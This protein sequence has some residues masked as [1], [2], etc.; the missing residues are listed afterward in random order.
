MPRAPLSFGVLV[1]LA[2]D[3][4]VL[5]AR[6]PGDEPSPVAAGGTCLEWARFAGLTADAPHESIRGTFD[7][8][9]DLGRN[10]PETLAH[11]TL[12]QLCDRGL[13]DRIPG[14]PHR[15][16]PRVGGVDRQLKRRRRRRT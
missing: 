7:R 2:A 13:V 4:F 6:P 1:G 14:L 10:D 12:Q 11:T 3:R 16:R 9:I 5:L 15:Y 8:C